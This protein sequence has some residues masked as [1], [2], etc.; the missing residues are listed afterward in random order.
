[1]FTQSVT[2]NYAPHSCHGLASTM[3]RTCF[4]MSLEQLV[5][6][7]QPVA[8]YAYASIASPVASSPSPLLPLSLSTGT[9]YVPKELARLLDVLFRSEVH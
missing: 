9:M 5:C 6:C 3:E 7:D 1:M 4:G 2:Y 8:M